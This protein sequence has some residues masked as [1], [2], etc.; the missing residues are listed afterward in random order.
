MLRALKNGAGAPFFKK[1]GSAAKGHLA[2]LSKE[3]PYGRGTYWK[4]VLP[5]WPPSMAALL[6]YGGH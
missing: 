5:Q 4:A 2:F 3:V 6:P 1:Q